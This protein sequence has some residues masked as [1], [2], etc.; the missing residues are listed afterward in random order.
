MVRCSR[1]SLKPGFT[2]VELLASIAIVGIL[3][4]MLLPA[5]Q[6]AREAARAA[7]CQNHL[8]QIGL[9]MENHVAAFRRYPSNG[10]GYLWIGDPDRGTDRNQ[11][12]GWVYNILPY[13]EQSPLR[14]M[15][16]GLAEAEKRGA[17]TE[18]TQKP[19]ELFDCPSR[20]GGLLSPL[21][22]TLRFRNADW[23]SKV[24]KTD[25]AVNEG[26]FITDTREGPES[27][28]E[29]AVREYA[30]SDTA[31]ASGIAYQRSE[32][33][34]AAIS[35]GLSNTYLAGEK[36]VSRDSYHDYADYGFDTSMYSGVDVDLSRW[37]LDPPE[38]DGAEIQERIFG[39]A[40]PSGCHFVLCDGAVRRIAYYVNADVHRR[41]GNRH[42]G[43]S[44]D[45]GSW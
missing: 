7:S 3:I 44:V 6:S 25:Y 13:I 12:G 33:A 37:V 24:A 35:D 22:P 20:P 2:L 38:C 10:W 14:E 36:Y 29:S 31:P 16:K 21:H 39:S 45:A 1:P 9:A 18:L 28:A 8:K 41:L 34:P 4:A 27:L 19:L 43:Q 30:W 17:L 11:P 15:G 23:S 42:D 40:H 32:V 5:V 26:D